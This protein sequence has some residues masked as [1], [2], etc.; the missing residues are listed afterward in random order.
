VI[1][2]KEALDRVVNGAFDNKHRDCHVV[3][4]SHSVDDVNIGE[5]RELFL[6]IIS[7]AA[8]SCRPVFVR[9]GGGSWRFARFQGPLANALLWCRV[10]SQSRRREK[11]L[12]VLDV[13]LLEYQRSNIFW[14][15]KNYLFIFSWRHNWVRLVVF[16]SR[17]FMVDKG[18]KRLRFKTTNSFLN[19]FY[20]Y[21]SK[22]VIL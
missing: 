10:A 15:T 12:V 16:I 17:I 14:L 4:S 11:G 19:N 9:G 18:V 5:N 20:K 13:S 3:N 8:N 1:L 22:K 21:I 6:K 7:L 2:S